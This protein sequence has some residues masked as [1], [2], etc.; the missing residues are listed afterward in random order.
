V[1]RSLGGLG[2]G[3]KDV[4]DRVAAVQTGRVRAYALALALGLAVIAVVFLLVA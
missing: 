1:L 3:V 2:T 4:S